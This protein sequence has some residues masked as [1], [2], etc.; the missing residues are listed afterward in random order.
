MILPLQKH[1]T[2]LG[3]ESIKDFAQTYF[4]RKSTVFDGI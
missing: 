1:Y 4:T 3:H 2:L